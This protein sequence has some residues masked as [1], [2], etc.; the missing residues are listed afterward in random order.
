MSRLLT[1]RLF[2]E[3][4]YDEHA[5]WFADEE[6]NREL[7]PMDREWLESVLANKPSIGATYAVSDGTELVAV[8]SMFYEGGGNAH[9]GAIATKPQRKR[10]GIGAEVLHWTMKHLHGKGVEIVTT[11]IHEANAPSYRLF[12]R[13]GFSPEDTVSP[14]GF[15]DYICVLGDE[16]NEETN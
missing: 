14:N 10:E 13:E 12:A 4:L 2:T 15:R 8:V 5:A 16:L 11:M 6:L 9:I 1:Y 3:D 7:G